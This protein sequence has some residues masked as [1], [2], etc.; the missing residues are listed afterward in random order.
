MEMSCCRHKVP[1]RK[2]SQ[3][4]FKEPDPDQALVFFCDYLITLA[5]YSLDK[6]AIEDLHPAACFPHSTPERQL[7]QGCGYSCSAHAEHHRKEIMRER[8]GV[9]VK[10]VMG[11]KKPSRQ[12]SFETMPSVAQ[13]RLRALDKKSLYVIH[14]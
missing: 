10:P 14:Q 6:S 13:R 11:K 7:L 5:A 12:P 1:D 2:R 8:N 4:M 9:A 3:R